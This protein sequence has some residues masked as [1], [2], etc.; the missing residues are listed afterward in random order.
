LPPDVVYARES[1]I[2]I[3]VKGTPYVF[4]RFTWLR[5]NGLL[6]GYCVAATED[7]RP[8][9]VNCYEAKQA[10]KFNAL[11]SFPY[12][13]DFVVLGLTMPNV[14]RVSLTRA[15][16]SALADAKNGYFTSVIPFNPTHYA[17]TL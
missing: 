9:G 15:H 6:R 10:K 2:R 7:V 12:G 3:P 11:Q 1:A 4:W 17:A 13:K 16:Q 5:R 8:A 14:H